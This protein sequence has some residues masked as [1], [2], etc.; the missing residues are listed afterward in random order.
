MGTAAAQTLVFALIVGVV[1]TAFTA[2]RAR[3][4]RADQS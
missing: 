1:A 2:A 3:T 4:V